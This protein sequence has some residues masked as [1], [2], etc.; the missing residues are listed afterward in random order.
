MPR[1]LWL[2]AALLCLGGCGNAQPRYGEVMVGDRSGYARI[3][4]SDSDRVLIRD[5]YA[6]R[7]RGLPPGLAKQGKIPPGHAWRMLRDGRLPPD[8]A[9]RYLPAELEGR[10]SRLSDGYV[11]IIVGSD[12]GI[13]HTRTRLV[14]DVIHDIAVH[15]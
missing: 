3:V 9:Y 4:F 8:V 14:A 1:N 15:D 10:L 13:L 11:R 5:Y 7:Y 2:I 6:N 12:I